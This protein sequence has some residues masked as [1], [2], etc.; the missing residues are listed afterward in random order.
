MIETFERLFLTMLTQRITAV[1]AYTG[2][3]HVFLCISM[4]LAMEVKAVSTILSSLDINFCVL[5]ILYA[6]I[7]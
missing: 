2:Q 7:E 6:Y 3:K 5:R 4:R 1:I